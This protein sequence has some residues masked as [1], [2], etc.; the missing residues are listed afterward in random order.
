MFFLKQT[1]YLVRVG[2]LIHI[3]FIFFFIAF[4]DNQ[5]F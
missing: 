1:V 5:A 3:E 4:K 2:K